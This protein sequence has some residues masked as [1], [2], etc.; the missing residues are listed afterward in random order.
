MHEQKDA[1]VVSEPKEQRIESIERQWRDKDVLEFGRDF[2]ANLSTGYRVRDQATRGAVR[3]LHA[4]ALTK[5][6]GCGIRPAKHVS[7]A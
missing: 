7:D 6:N 1:V 2:P 3:D 4:M 5:C